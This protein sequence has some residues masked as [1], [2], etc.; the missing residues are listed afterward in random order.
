M[1]AAGLHGVPG[2]LRDAGPT[3]RLGKLERELVRLAIDAT[4]THRYV[5][6]LRFH[7]G[8]AVRLGASKAQ[9][10]EVLARAAR[11]PVH[12]GVASHFARS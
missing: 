10:R 5:P 1:V 9:V 12:V 7:V 4:P 3:G 6:G 8:C 2:L 11:A